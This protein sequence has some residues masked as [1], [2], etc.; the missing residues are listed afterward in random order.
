MGT[1]GAGRCLTPRDAAID[2]RAGY[3]RAKRV[4]T[5]AANV[6]SQKLEIALA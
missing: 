3:R 1:G 6:E 2:E 5:P 4:G